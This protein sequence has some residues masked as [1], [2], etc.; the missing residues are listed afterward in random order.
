MSAPTTTYEN[1]DDCEDDDD[2]YC[3]CDYYGDHDCYNPPRLLVQASFLNVHTGIQQAIGDE[4]WIL[5]PVQVAVCLCVTPCSV[6]APTQSFG[7]VLAK[8]KIPNPSRS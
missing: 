3:G 5:K 7:K 6:A 4:R 2:D 8:S 1:R